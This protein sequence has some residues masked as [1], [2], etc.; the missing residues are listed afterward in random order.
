MVSRVPGTPDTVWVTELW[1]S[2]AAMNDAL[3]HAQAEQSDAIDRVMEHVAEWDRTDLEPAGGVGLP[4]RPRPGWQKVS[5]DEVE[6]QAPKSGLGEIQEMRSLVAALGLERT[7][8]TLQRI[9]P[10][11]RQAFGHSHVNAE[12]VYVVLAGSGTL[13]LDGDE[14]PLRAREAVRMAPDLMRAV[15]A[16]PDGL[17]YLAVGARHQGDFAMVPG[18]WGADAD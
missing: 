9:L 5:L 17:E 8:I 1:A 10:G 4:E 15:E 7:G 2:E 18:W 14:V 3:A 16:G 12:E 11:Q 13:R 6:D